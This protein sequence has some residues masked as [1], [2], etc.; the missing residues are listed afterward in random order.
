[1]RTARASLSGS[2]L[3]AL[4]V[5]GLLARRVVTD[6]RLEP[7]V[8]DSVQLRLTAEQAWLLVEQLD[9]IHSARC[10]GFNTTDG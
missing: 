9:L 3:Q 2:N 4:G 6:F 10:G 7:L 8:F 1:M 5:Y